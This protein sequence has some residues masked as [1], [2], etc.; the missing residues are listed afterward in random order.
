MY[1]ASYTVSG[2]QARRMVLQWLWRMRGGL[3]LGVALVFCLSVAVAILSQADRIFFAFCAGAACCYLVI[4]VTAVLRA[5]TARSS[6][7][8]EV[9]L[10]MSDDALTLA[11]SEG[12][13]EARWPAFRRVIATTDFLFLSLHGSS[14]AVAI[15]RA[16]L[17]S[18]AVAFL[19]ERVG[20]IGTKHEADV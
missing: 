6:Q 1:E 8:G 2:A 13:S 19:C 7:L 17:S 9:S 4:Y 20:T 5:R 18:E 15:P 10:G 16:A 3:L 12:R 14:R 11:W